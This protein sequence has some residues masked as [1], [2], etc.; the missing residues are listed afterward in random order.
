[1]TRENLL[2]GSRVR[3]GQK[4]VGLAS[5]GLHTNGYSLARRVCF[6]EFGLKARRPPAELETGRFATHSSRRTAATARC[7]R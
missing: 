1:M 2:D 7:C 3:A 4:L 5:D 6:D